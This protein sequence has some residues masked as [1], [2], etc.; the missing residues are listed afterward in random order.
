MT[1][2]EIVRNKLCNILQTNADLPIVALVNAD[3]LQIQR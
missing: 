1:E 3:V 2:S